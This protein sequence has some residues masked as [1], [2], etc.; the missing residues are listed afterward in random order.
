MSSAKI[1]FGGLSL[2]PADAQW[3]CKAIRTGRDRSLFE[4]D[5]IQVDALDVSESDHV[6]DAS[7]LVKFS[8]ARR[9]AFQ[10]GRLDGPV[11]AQ[12]HLAFLQPLVDLVD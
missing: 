9:G 6:L 10:H 5:R 3:M 12:H 4:R 2:S 8:D 7:E 1:T 11:D